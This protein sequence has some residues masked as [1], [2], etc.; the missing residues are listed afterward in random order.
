[1][2]IHYN[3]AIHVE[4]SPTEVLADIMKCPRCS[5]DA[6]ANAAYCPQCGA[7][8]QGGSDPKAASP[9]PEGLAADL[10]NAAMRNLQR[11]ARLADE[12]ERDVWQGCYSP[13]AMVGVW[14]IL[15]LLT[16]GALFIGSL[17]LRYA[18]Q[19]GVLLGVVALGWLVALGVLIYRRIG[20]RYR[21]TT[22]RLFHEKGVLKRTIDRIELIKVDD[23]TSEQGVFE[24]MMGI[25]SIRIKSS[26]RTDPDFW[27]RGVENARNVATEIDR[28]R[29][30]E[31]VRRGLL[32]ATGGLGVDQAG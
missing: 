31:Q 2:R 15:A 20:V 4:A 5:A 27:I 13:R 7:A 32:I 12:P 28:A 21:L 24:R 10:P 23:I 25:G 11:R 17:Q 26:D 6:P 22:Q 29:R 3:P 8:L 19:W 1:M 14:F 16:L 30:A 18:W 9:P